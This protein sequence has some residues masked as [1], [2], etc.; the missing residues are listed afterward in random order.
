MMTLH[1]WLTR[2][3]AMANPMPRL[4]P[5][6]RAVLPLNA[7]PVLEG[8]LVAIGAL[9]DQGEKFLARFLLVAEAA[10]HGR[11][12]SGGMLLLD[13]THHHAKVAGFD[14]NADALRFNDVLDGFGDLGCQP[15]LNLQ[16]PR[17]N[18]DE[19]RNFA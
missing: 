6:M 3:L 15:F 17:E 18:L 2:A 13:A 19:A 4:P 10:Q 9:A 7:A 12:H 8:R 1:A 14:D 5:E 11:G 16:A